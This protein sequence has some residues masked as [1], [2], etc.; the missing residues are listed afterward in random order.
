MTDF[1]KSIGARLRQQRLAKGISQ[2]KLA[3]AM[4]VSFQQV[5]KYETGRNRISATRLAN[6]AAA[7]NCDPSIFFP[8]IK[9]VGSSNPEAQTPD[10]ISLLTGFRSARPDQRAAILTIVAATATPPA[11]AAE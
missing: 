9:P 5:Q 10:E 4:G 7:L 6:A 1:N 11:I 2:A 8:R 3:E